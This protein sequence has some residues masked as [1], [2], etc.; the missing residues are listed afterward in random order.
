MKFKTPAPFLLAAACI[1]LGSSG[2]SLFHH[3]Q[4]KSGWKIV[5]V[6]DDSPFITDAPTRAG[7]ITRTVDVS[8]SKPQQSR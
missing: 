7:T 4:P 5:D 6:N 2:C 3:H 8:D 1:F